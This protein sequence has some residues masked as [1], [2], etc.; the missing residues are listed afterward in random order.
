[1]WHVIRR[2]HCRVASG[3]IIRFV[4]TQMLRMTASRFGSLHDDCFQSLFQEF[5]I[6]DIGR[7]NHDRQRPTSS[8]GQNAAFRP[9]FRSIGGV[10][11]N[12]APPNRALP[13]AV[14]AACQSH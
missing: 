9:V 8:I 2:R 7:C 14:S 4:Q 5:G 11:T 13:M 3:I 1:M 6:V 10:G 12:R